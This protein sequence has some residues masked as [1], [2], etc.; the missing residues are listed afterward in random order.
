MSKSSTIKVFFDT[1]ILYTNQAHLLLPRKVVDYIRD[2]RKIESVEIKWHIPRM[3]I[4]ERRHQ[5]S[6][7]AESLMPKVNDLEKL[8][9]HN[10]GINSEVL[11]DRITSKINKAIEEHGLEIL[12]LDSSKINLD[13]II[14]RSVKRE[15]PFEESR[16]TEKGFRDAV[17]ANAFLQELERSPTTPRVCRLVFITGDSRLK[18]YLEEKTKGKANVR[19]METLDDLKSLINAIASEVTEEF[20]TAILDKAMRVFYDFETKEGLYSSKKVYE[21]IT[22]KF[23][24]ELNSVTGGKVMVRRVSDGVVL[25]DQTFIDKIGQIVHWTREVLLKF[26]VEEF[27]SL[28][29]SSTKLS[30][31]S[32]DAPE[33]K[34]LSTGVSRFLVHWQHQISTNEKISRPKINKIEFIDH[35][36][37]DPK[38]G[39]IN[40]LISRQS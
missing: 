35:E 3:V 32:S 39:I 26:R 10:L 36:I 21:E 27:T 5:M 34:V 24:D 2:H 28:G 22:A 6:V 40:A 23:K 25:G 29:L 33:T 30:L 11:N 19:L 38:E 16:E 8:I 31:L 20:L 13:D 37:N 18:E 12:E 4:E 9:G 1:N 15:P 14:D 7:S 17:I